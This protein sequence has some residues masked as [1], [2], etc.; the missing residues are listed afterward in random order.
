MTELPNGQSLLREAESDPNKIKLRQGPIL[1]ATLLMLST[2][3]LPRATATVA[4]SMAGPAHILG[5]TK[6][7]HHGEYKCPTMSGVLSHSA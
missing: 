1:P 6:Y 4:A 2:A 7:E 5:T 3:P